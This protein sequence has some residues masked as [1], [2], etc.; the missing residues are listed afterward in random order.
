MPW[1]ANARGTPADTSLYYERGLLAPGVDDDA[2]LPYPRAPLDALGGARCV[3]LSQRPGLGYDIGWD[4]IQA[5][6]LAG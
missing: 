1:R 3:Y 5:R 4:Y 6:T 2:P